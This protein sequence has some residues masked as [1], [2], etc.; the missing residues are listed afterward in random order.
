MLTIDTHKNSSIENLCLLA[1]RLQIEQRLQGKQCLHFLARNMFHL[2][3]KM[4]WG[5]CV[6]ARDCRRRISAHFGKRFFILSEHRNADGTYAFHRLR[7]C[8]LHR[9][10]SATFDKP[11]TPGPVSR[12]VRKCVQHLCLRHLLLQKIALG[13]DRAL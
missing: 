13:G 1:G 10:I 6:H 7:V 5:A 11:M 9:T 3:S 12:P 4:P 2:L 8:T